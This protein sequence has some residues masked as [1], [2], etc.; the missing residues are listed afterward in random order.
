MSAVRERIDETSA[1]VMRSL[2]RMSNNLSQDKSLQT[3]SSPTVSLSPV[4]ECIRHTGLRLCQL[5]KGRMPEYLPDKPRLSEID[6]EQYL[7]ALTD[8]QVYT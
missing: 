5:Y 1:C 3:Q 7:R 8:D 2:L 6:L 4:T